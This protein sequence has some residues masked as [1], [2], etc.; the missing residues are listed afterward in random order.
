MCAMHTSACQLR[1]VILKLTSL[2]LGIRR[3]EMCEMSKNLQT[4][5]VKSQR[6]E[7]GLNKLV[8]MFE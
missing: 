6:V 4:N 5:F 1:G 7:T 3:N 2:E 8:R